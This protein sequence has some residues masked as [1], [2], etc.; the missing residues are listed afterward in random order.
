MGIMGSTV[1][2]VYL[3]VLD[4]YIEGVEVFCWARMYPNVSGMYLRSL[5]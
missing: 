5:Q 2:A 1:E 4:V 3:S